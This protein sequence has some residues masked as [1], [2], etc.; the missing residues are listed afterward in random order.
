M[1]FAYLIVPRPICDE[2]AYL[3]PE[4]RA[5][6]GRRYGDVQGACGITRPMGT[7]DAAE[8]HRDLLLIPGSVPA[9]PPLSLQ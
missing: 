5:Q 9:G 4:F 2:K 1:A 8:D 7:F 6:P 3:E